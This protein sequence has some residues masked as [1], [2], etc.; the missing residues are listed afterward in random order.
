M[1]TKSNK[2][3]G[4][5]NNKT[6]LVD[7]RKIE[8][9][10]IYKVNKSITKKAN[11]KCNNGA[12]YIKRE[13][14]NWPLFWLGFFLLSPIG[15]LILGSFIPNGWKKLFTEQEIKEISRIKA[16]FM[17]GDV[18]EIRECFKIIVKDGNVYY[19][20]PNAF[21]SWVLIF[22]QFQ[23]SGETAPTIDENPIVN[24]IASEEI[25]NM[26]K[27]SESKP[28]CE[29]SS[30]EAKIALIIFGIVILIAIIAGIVV[31]VSS[32]NN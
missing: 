12:I 27:E 32:L 19:I 25:E 17:N 22:N 29:P 10:G 1:L 23:I 31:A 21:D 24:S 14:F 28:I 6:V 4:V 16:P 30:K 18:E 2:R 15:G 5:F 3:S 13:G 26:E 20:C 7:D 9:L 8:S 11:F